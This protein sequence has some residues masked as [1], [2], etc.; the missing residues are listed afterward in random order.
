[1]EKPSNEKQYVRK[2]YIVDK[3]F[4]LKYTLIIA[5]GA[6]VISIGFGT[7]VYYKTTEATHVASTAMLRWSEPDLRGA[8]GLDMDAEAIETIKGAMDEQDRNVL[9]AIVLFIAALV[10]VLTLWGILIT[11]RIA[12]PLFAISRY[13][14]QIRAGKLANVRPLRKKDELKE[15]FF[16]FNEMVTELRSRTEAEIT[17]LEGIA[18]RLNDLKSEGAEVEALQAQINGMLESKREYLNTPA[19]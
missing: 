5:L 19:E 10:V 8:P 17:T 9:L 16:V 7:A 12:G 11:H 18:L 14:G 6:A 1:M 2:T 13:L 15:F 3:R 4:Q